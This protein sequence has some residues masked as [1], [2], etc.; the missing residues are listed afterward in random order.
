MTSKDTSFRSACALS[1]AL[2]IIGD[3]WSLLIIRDICLHKNRYNDFHSS[4]EGIPTNILA[5]RL[6]RLEDN[7]IIQKQPYQLKPKRFEYRLTPK[8]ADLLPVMQQLA[9]WAHRYIPECGE[10]P[11]EFLSAEPDQLLASNIFNS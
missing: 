1:T 2:D 7:G 8:G 10:P 5:S 9:I 3:K 6:R 11:A 4:P